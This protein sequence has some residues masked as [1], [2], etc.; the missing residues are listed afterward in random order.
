LP[1]AFIFARLRRSLSTFCAKPRDTT[2]RGG[3]PWPPQ[4]ENNNGN[5][6]AH[7]LSS[8]RS[9]CPTWSSVALFTVP[10]TLI[11]RSVETERMSSHFMKLRTCSPP[12]GGFI[13]TC[14]GIP[15]S[16]DVIGIAITKS[17]GLRF[18]LSSDT[19]RHGRRPAC[20]RPLVGL[21]STNQIS[22]R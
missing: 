10:N 15:L 22:P 16:F 13:W 6:N 11:N 17:A 5:L 14:E 19:I 12:S 4:L 9:R 1:L 2:F 7:R 3:P 8:N 21:R 18:S 20:S